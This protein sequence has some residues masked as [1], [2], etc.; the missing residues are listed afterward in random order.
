MVIQIHYDVEKQK[1]YPDILKKHL[2]VRAPYVK[3]RKMEIDE[4]IEISKELVCL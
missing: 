4:T 3:V 2:E 1:D